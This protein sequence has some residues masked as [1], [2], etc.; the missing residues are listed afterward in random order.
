MGYWG[1]MNIH[2]FFVFFSQWWS[3]LEKWWSVFHLSCQVALLLSSKYWQDISGQAWSKSAEYKF[4]FFPLQLCLGHHIIYWYFG[5][6]A[7]NQN[8]S[9][10][11]GLRIVES[12]LE[13][14]W[15]LH[16]LFLKSFSSYLVSKEESNFQFRLSHP[17]GNFDIGQKWE[18]L[19]WKGVINAMA[20]YTLKKGLLFDLLALRAANCQAI[21]T[22]HNFSLS[23]VASWV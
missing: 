23:K 17:C 21:M 10:S 5:T 19:N 4:W 18:A 1:K 12:R 8:V 16:F 14:S 7:E 6:P 11:K 22:R 20:R 15:F 3:S 13:Q 9:T 2:R